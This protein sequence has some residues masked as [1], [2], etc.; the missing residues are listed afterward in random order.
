MEEKS[1]SLCIYRI[2]EKFLRVSKNSYIP[3]TVSIGP[4]HH[5]NPSL[6]DMENN[7]WGYL[8]ALL[9]RK[10]MLEESLDECVKSIRELEQRARKCYSESENITLSSD[11]FVEMLL[12]DGC[13]I[14]EL[15]FKYILKG[16]RRKGDRVFN[17]KSM[18]PGIRRDLILLENQI[19]LFVLQRLYD[20]VP[21]PDQLQR[22]S[23]SQIAFRFFKPI[24]PGNK[25]VLESKFV[26]EGGH[27]LDLLRQCYLSLLPRVMPLANQHG[28]QEHLHSARKLQK[29]GITIKKSVQ[30][31]LLDLKFVRGELRIPPL[32]IYDYTESILRN[33]VALEQC[34]PEYTKQISSYALLMDNLIRSNKDARLLQQRGIIVNRLDS[35]EEVTSL[36]NNLCKEIEVG[37]SYY[38]GLCQQVNSYCNSNWHGQWSKLRN[39]L[40]PYLLQIFGILLL[41]SFTGTIFSVL[42]FFLHHS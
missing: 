30:D 10:T 11:Q 16:L 14:I 15:F 23:L 21:I 5:G 38:V 12:V 32:K 6:S 18:L 29:T 7:K 9:G 3:D 20:L 22:Q 33:L 24:I 40:H 26:H 1:P 34:C 41:L 36:F 4:F 19:P 27:L 17:T 2:P 8:H 39:E 31:S 37:E 13:F 25:E 28:S 42:S 35:D